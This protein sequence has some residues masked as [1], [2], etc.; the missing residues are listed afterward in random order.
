[1]AAG[2]S[3]IGA[4]RVELGIDS[5]QF[6][7]GLAR[8]TTG[9]GR[10]QNVAL[11]GFAA[12]TAAAVVAG[13]ALV[14]ALG[15]AIDSFDEMGKAA[16]RTGVAVEALSQLKYAADLSDVSFQQLTGGLQRLSKGIGEIASGSSGPAA[17]AFAALGVSATNAAGQMR[18]ADEV[19][20][21]LAEQ[22]ASLEDGST[23]TALAI[24]IFG[25][26]GAEMI[27][28]LNAGRD[29]LREAAAE[30]DRYGL[31]VSGRAAKGAEVFNDNLTRLN[32][33]FQGVINRVANYLIPAL[34]DLSTWFVDAALDS[35]VLE[36]A[37]NGLIWAFHNVRIAVATTIATIEVLGSALST[38]GQAMSFA[39]GGN[40][41]MASIAAQQGWTDLT[42]KVEEYRD[43]L[44]QIDYDFWDNQTQGGWGRIKDRTLGAAGDDAPDD[45]NKRVIDLGVLRDAN[46]AAAD[47]QKFLNEQLAA[48]QSVLDATRNPIEIM[49]QELLNLGDLLGESGKQWEL[50]GRAASIAV[51]NAAA[52]TLGSLGSLSSGLSQ[53]FQ[54]NRTL[55]IATAVLKGAEAVASAFA[56]GSVY[57]PWGGAAF[58]A[59]A[60]ITA[61]AN[62]AAVAAVGP[63]STSMS[64]APSTPSVPTP[65]AS[66]PTGPTIN[67]TLKG[68]GLYSRNEVENLFRAMNDAMGD[69]IRLNVNQA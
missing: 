45:T 7:Q 57:G 48:V 52:S 56:A 47:S 61:A 37:A 50:Y 27:P 53:A 8:A 55:A 64:G 49:Q 36:A 31:T 42:T 32:S 51:A 3:V 11:A 54:D 35:G 60:A 59:V 4:L 20:A 44:N 10:W 68:G 33:M 46:L 13:R 34:A 65:T 62:V 29:G 66:S 30:A 9:L 43:E 5:A 2:N 58:A 69:G 1:M 22:F 6:E 24:A 23:K 40:W 18:S 25:R 14:G 67:L 26:A 15:D 16:Q 19:F 39:L 38:V 17:M 63:T 12:V 41:Q 21:D 28:L